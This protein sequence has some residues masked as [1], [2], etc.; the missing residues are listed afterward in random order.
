MYILPENSGYYHINMF[1][2]IEEE[3]VNAHNNEIVCFLCNFNACTKNDTDL[4]GVD[5]D[6]LDALDLA[7]YVKDKIEEESML[8][9]LRFN[10]NRVSQDNA[11]NNY[12]YRLLE[13][14]TNIGVCVC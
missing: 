3:F 9:E 2:T 8:E 10:L 6:M 14:C 7:D 13:R 5:T 12:C 1:D 11:I 4:V